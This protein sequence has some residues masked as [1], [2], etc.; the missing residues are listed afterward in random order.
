MPM[1]QAAAAKPTH[2]DIQN[3]INLASGYINALYKDSSPAEV[4]SSTNAV[5]AEYPALPIRVVQSDGRVIRAGEDVNIWTGWK[6]NV[7]DTFSETAS[8]SIKYRI[9]MRSKD[10]FNSVY[11]KSPLL[12]VTVDYDYGASHNVKV[13]V[14]NLQ[15]D[16]GAPV[17]YADVYIGNV[18]LGR[19][20][21]A[22]VGTTWSYTSSVNNSNDVFFRS[23][24]YIER[25]GT[26][27]G[28]E[29][30]NAVGDTSKATELANRL[31][32]EGYTLSKDIY[33]PMFGSASAQ[34]TNYQYES[35]STG[36]YRDCYTEPSLRDQ[37]YQ[38]HSKVCN[39]VDAYIIYSRSS[40]WL[41]PTLWAIHQ[42]NKGVGVDT[43]IYDGY[44][45]WSPRQVARFVEG[46]WIADI[47]VKS[48]YSNTQASAVRT[49][50]FLTL[51][52]MLG[53]G[54]TNDATSRT[55]ADKAASALLNPQIKSNGVVTRENEDGSF[56]SLTRPLLKGGVY[57]AWNGFNY[58]TKNSILQSMSDSFN[59]PDETLDIK[60]SNAES[61]IT[62]AQALRVYDCYNYGSNCLNTP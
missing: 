60:P 41:V 55:Y 35:G 57:T 1:Q 3:V 58:V 8:D 19:A 14:K 62:V 56:T 26:Q 42:L 45:T 27:L 18:Y 47:G 20:T 13:D 32:S 6:T 61:T 40:D 31:T 59:Q 36:V 9:H 5:M 25:H 53:Y 34:A 30:Y 38:Y 17:S 51:E 21:P 54:S 2:T 43:P 7:L 29:W 37:S 23:F 49:A 11:D 10:I 4:G 50:A 24:R 15:W 46:K 33:S 22:N 44:Q 48:P 16:A 12:E 52:T 28:R 39:G